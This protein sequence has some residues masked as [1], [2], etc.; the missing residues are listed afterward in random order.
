[1]ISMEGNEMAKKLLIN[2]ASCDARK[3][4]EENYSAYESITVNAATVL[5]SAASKAVM[6]RLPFALNCANVIEVE[7][8]VDLRTVNGKAEIK[9]DD[10][11]PERKFYMLVNGVLNI[12]PDT[13]KQLAQCV[14]MTVNG[15][16]LC[17]ESLYAT[18]GNVKVNG[19]SAC[20]P[21]GAIVLRRNAVIDKLFALRAKRALYWA[22]RRLI[23]VDPELD[24]EA[25][26]AKGAAFSAAEVIVAQSKVEA[27]LGLIDE[28][29]DIVIVPDGTAVVLDDLTLDENALRRC[30]RRLYVIGDVTSPRTAACSAR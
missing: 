12:G 27:L 6:N 8:D 13:Q 20:Y 2:C 9:S 14:G 25:L 28:K 30:G 17:P 29:A 16:L 4:Q 26:R 3:I 1:M 22:A 10:A 21:D 19:A 24:A 11:V 15:S 7:G 5:A 18:L 23:M